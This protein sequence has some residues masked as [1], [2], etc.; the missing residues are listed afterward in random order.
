[1]YIPDG[2]ST[3]GDAAFSSN[4]LR[5]VFIPD[6]VRFIGNQ[7]FGNN[8]LMEI[9]IGENVNIREDSF[10]Q[11][12]YKAYLGNSKQAGTYTNTGGAWTYTG[13]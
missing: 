5:S 1:V 2:V 6:S 12:F 8:P 4:S 10:P 13:L 7:A 3:I 11:N 9:S